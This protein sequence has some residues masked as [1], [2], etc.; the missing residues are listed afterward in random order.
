MRWSKCRMAH[1]GNQ[2]ICMQY[3]L[4][5]AKQLDVDPR[6]CV[7]YFLKR[8]QVAEL[9]YKKQFRWAIKAFQEGIAKQARIKKQ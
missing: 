7:K 8:I 5:F 3:I 6:T 4:D 9:D 2:S 1:I